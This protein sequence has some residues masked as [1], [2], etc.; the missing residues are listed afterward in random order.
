MPPAEL[1]DRLMDRFVRRPL[2]WAWIAIAVVTIVAVF[3]GALV[4]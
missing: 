1:P 3:L 2:K 4:V